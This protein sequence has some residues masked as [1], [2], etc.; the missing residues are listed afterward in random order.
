MADAASR[1]M[2]P[3]DV[4]AH[5]DAEPAVAALIQTLAGTT[6]GGGATAVSFGT[7]NS[8]GTVTMGDVAGR[9][10]IKISPNIIVHLT[11]SGLVRPMPPNHRAA[12]MRMVED[13]QAVFGGRTAEL[14]GLD[15]FLE[16][17]EQSCACC[18][19]RPGGAR[20]RC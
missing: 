14:A 1:A 8:I 3:D 20:P 19:P 6:I 17:S 18:W 15:A 2:S 9:D 12:V 11:Y 7:G 5:L 4:Q 16:Q 10:I 13:Y